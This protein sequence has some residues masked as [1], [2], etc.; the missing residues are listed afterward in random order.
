MNRISRSLGIVLV[1]TLVLCA[2][3]LGYW[4]GSRPNPADADSS[5]QAKSD[6]NN[7]LY[8]YDPMVPQEHYP[9]PG[10]SS[11]NMALIPK[12]ADDDG[13][14]SSGI[15]IAPGVR[16]NLGIRTVTAKQG[17]LANAV[18]VPGTIA[19]DMRQERV[20]SARV[21]AI[22]ERLYIKAPFEPVRAGQPLASVIA[23][24][25]STALA[26]ADAL[27]GAG[28]GPAR[29]LRSASQTRLRALGLPAGSGGGR[30]GAITLNAPITGVVTEIGAREGQAAPAG[31]LLFRINGD[32]TVWVD[33]AIPQAG[34]AGVRSGTPVT[35]TVDA[36]PGQ[37]FAG[38]IEN[39]LPQI[40]PGNRTQRARIVLDNPDGALAPGMFAQVALEPTGG[41]EHI[42]VPS[43]AVVSPGD[44]PRVIVLGDDK[45]FHPVAVST[46]RSSGGMTEILSGLKGGERVVASGQFLIDSEANLSGALDR[47]GAARQDHQSHSPEPQ[48]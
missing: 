39:V 48:P 17:R 9:G 35:V 38:R 2:L 41:S 40:D 34:A 5:S 22:V 45:T 14:K 26:E 47:L 21:D 46:G 24:A 12:Y 15:T 16:Q 10:K 44:Q 42:V 18:R 30:G 28:S 33:A 20:V 4:W 3:G 8:W 25:W 32:A 19:W 1:V 7:I 29:A 23:P 11:M 43:D 36:L 31:T 13:A 27:N 6:K 37:S